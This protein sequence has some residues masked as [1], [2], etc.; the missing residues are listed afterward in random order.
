M[1]KPCFPPTHQGQDHPK[2]I[3]QGKPQK[4]LKTRWPRDLDYQ[5]DIKVEL[6]T[7]KELEALSVVQRFIAQIKMVPTSVVGDYSGSGSD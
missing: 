6:L 3:A 7:E 4:Y 2:Q 5:E 1:F